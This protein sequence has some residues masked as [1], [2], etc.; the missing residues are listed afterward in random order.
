MFFATRHLLFLFVSV[1]TK[2]CPVNRAL[3]SCFNS[4]A[5]HLQM[6]SPCIIMFNFVRGKNFA[7]RKLFLR[8]SLA[9][10]HSSLATDKDKGE[11]NAQAG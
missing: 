8:L 2:G 5:N 3:S 9:T 6:L 1:R 7:N 11:M 4:A 10:S